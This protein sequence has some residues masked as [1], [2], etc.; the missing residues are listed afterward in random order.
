MNVYLAGPWKARH[1][2][3]KE[4]RERLRLAG[5]VVDCRWIDF[6]ETAEN[7]DDESVLVREAE[8]D[9][10]DIC[11]SQALMVLNTTGIKSEGKA[12]EQGI[13]H[14]MGIPV[15]VVG[16]YSHIFQRLDGFTRVDTI[17]EAITELHAIRTGCAE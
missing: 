13:A 10:T 11:L 8:N 16:P 12:C 6:D 7:E 15:V 9:V 1:T 3:V 14:A 5:F 4:A 2:E 17:S